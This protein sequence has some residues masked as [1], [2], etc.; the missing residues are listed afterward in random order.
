MTGLLTVLEHTHTHTSTLVLSILHNNTEE[1]PQLAVPGA[2]DTEALAAP[3]M[4][5]STSSGPACGGERLRALSGIPASAGPTAGTRPPF[6]PG[7]SPEPPRPCPAAPPPAP[8][9]APPRSLPAPSAGISWAAHGRAGPGAQPA[10]SAAVPPA[11]AA[12]TLRPQRP[13]A[14][15]PVLRPLPAGPPPPAGVCWCF[16]SPPPF[17]FLFYYIF[18]G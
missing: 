16:A 13:E 15:G 11:A 3:W 4:A 17:F 2:P 1:Q 12:G 9:P 8:V 18:S 14:A 6:A 10:R 7:G 5:G